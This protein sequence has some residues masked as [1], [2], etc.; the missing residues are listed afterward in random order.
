MKIESFTL[1]LMELIVQFESIFPD[2]NH[3]M[4][5]VKSN[6]TAPFFDGGMPNLLPS[7]GIFKANEASDS[8]G[9]ENIRR[10]VMTK[11]IKI[12]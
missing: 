2:W 4:A 9:K 10:G 1:C 5:T 8:S 3:S 6:A 12:A 11:S 7:I